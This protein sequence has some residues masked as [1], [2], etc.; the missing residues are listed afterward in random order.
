MAEAVQ[1]P[2]LGVATQA[3]GEGWRWNQE[4]RATVAGGD[5]REERARDKI[6]RSSRKDHRAPTRSGAGTGRTRKMGAARLGIWDRGGCQLD[7]DG[8]MGAAG[9]G[10]EVGRGK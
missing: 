10:W 2:R 9:S 3:E 8:G 7:R 1:T 6:V 4:G 5:I